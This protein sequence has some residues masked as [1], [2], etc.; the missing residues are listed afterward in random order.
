MT[1]FEKEIREMNLEQIL[2]KKAEI[3]TEIRS[4]KA[5]EE[6]GG[7]QEQIDLINQ[8]IKEL[9][10]LE[11]RKQTAEALQNGEITADKVIEERKEKRL[12]I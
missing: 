11:T 6:L 10:E 12:W 3:D 7:K 5:K 2:A 1:D 8:R 9:Q 4:A